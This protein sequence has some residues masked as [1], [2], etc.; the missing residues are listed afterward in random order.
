M[1]QPRKAH[2]VQRAR[3]A[4]TDRSAPLLRD[5]EGAGVPVKVLA[6]RDRAEAHCRQLHRRAA[7]KVIPFEYGVPFGHVDALPFLAAYTSLPTED[8]LRLLTDLGVEPP[9]LPAAG[10]PGP[11]RPATRPGAPGGTRTP[12][13]GPRPCSNAFGPPSTRCGCTRCWRCPQT[14]EGQHPRTQSPLA[15]T[16]P[17]SPLRKDG[18]SCSRSTSSSGTVLGSCW[19]TSTSKPPR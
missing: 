18:S 4:Y 7:K 8:F 9:N 1:R 11:P 15:R 19:A 12:S 14:C 16:S 10:E 13:G 2:V 6:D 3:W 17:N 5:E